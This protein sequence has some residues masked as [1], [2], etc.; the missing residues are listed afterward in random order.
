MKISSGK[1]KNKNIATKIKGIKV[2]YTPTSLKTRQAIFNI[3]MHNYMPESGLDDMVVADLCSGSGSLG[4]EALSRG[5]KHG[6]FVDIDNNQIK[7]A[8][9]NAE[10]LNITDQCTFICSDARRLRSS[11]H[12]CDIVFMD[13]P[14][15]NNISAEIL[16]ALIGADWLA[17]SSII[18][19]ECDKRVDLDVPPAFELLEQRLYGRVKVYFLMYKSKAV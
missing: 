5:A 14:Y 3:L 17:K 7:L 16:E 4:L 6:V 10:N 18:I 13:A 9:A 11:N 12:H 15:K 1:F 8:R 19:V 2:E